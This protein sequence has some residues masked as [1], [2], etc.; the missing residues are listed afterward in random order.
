MGHDGLHQ[1]FVLLKAQQAAAQQALNF[2]LLCLKF[3]IAHG[4]VGSGVQQS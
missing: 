3:V 1:A 4:A 2:S